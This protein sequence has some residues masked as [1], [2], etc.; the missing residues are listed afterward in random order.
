MKTKMLLLLMLIVSFYQP[1]VSN[2]QN[3]I[4]ITRQE[5]TT[6]TLSINDVTVNED[7][8]SVIALF[9]VTL[10]GDEGSDV[11][12]DYTTSSD[13]ALAGSDYVAT[14]GTLYFLSGSGILTQTITVTI[15]DDNIYEGNEYFNVNLINVYNAILADA[16]GSCLI[17]DFD[18]IPRLSV[19][20]NSAVEDAGVAQLTVTKVGLTKFPITVNFATADSTAIAG[21]DYVQTTG[22]I[23]FP[24]F[25]ADP[26][27]ISINLLDDNN[28]E[29]NEYFKVSLTFADN[30]FFNDQ[31]A[32]FTI[33]DD[34]EVVPEI[35]ISDAQANEG[36]TG[37]NN[38]MQFTLT[39][40][41]ASSQTVTVDAATSAGT[42]AAGVDFTSIA[43][44][45]VTFT[46]GQ[47]T[48]TMT[49]TL[50]G[51]NIDEND[52]TF[53]VNLSNA[54]N[55]EISDN[56]ATGTILDDDPQP[57][58]TINDVS[59]IEGASG[60]TTQAIFTLTLI[61]QTSKLVTVSASTSDNTA[62]TAGN[63][64]IAV[65]ATTITFN[66]GETSK[67]F[68]VTV[69]GDNMDE[70]DET[71]VVNLSGATNATISDNQATGTIL[72]DDPQPQITINDVSVNEG[73]SG[74][75]TQ[76]IFTLSLSSQTSKQ[77]TVSAITSDNTAT[78]AGNDY[79]AVNSTL[80]TFNPGD[81]SKTFTVTVNGDNADESD[82]SFLVNLSNAA[83][84][85]ISDNQALGTILDD[86]P[87]PSLSINDVSVTEGEE[88]STTTAVFVVTLT[89]LTNRQVTVTASTA[90]SSATIANEDYAAINVMELMFAPGETT[91]EFP[92]T[93]NGDSLIEASEYFKVNLST[94]VN[95]T[96]SDGSGIG[97][98]LND[99]FQVGDITG[100]GTIDNNDLLIIANMIISADELTPEL[101]A[102]IDFNHDG[103]ANILDIV[104]IIEQMLA[105]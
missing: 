16:N 7:G 63:D 22:S 103:V 20:D 96:I 14:N 56:Q 10:S 6:P 54:V 46:P 43:N 33:I 50:I 52:E 68:A 41:A 67:T 44:T 60:S 92:V 45:V 102:R 85:T 38:Q 66:P 80:I 49:V 53:V 3:H 13:D 99:D 51:D 76:A 98:I 18:P 9:T 101:L 87:L 95:A 71:F 36:N 35:T 62:T 79:T 94:P 1:I 12:V 2:A 72:D 104:Q 42:A 40:S 26:Q 91:K 11:W 55:A 84:A 15:L 30:A 23:L 37:T 81:T 8:A 100:D 105:K 61:G 17:T 77:V 83:N 93:V 82:E 32:I 97:T 34:D 90:D 88:D 24:A 27:T 21:E 86:D 89:G 4:E 48:K 28:M 65:S 5:P 73:A 78:T 74:S 64:Y 58:I 39:L 25:S 59:V 75:T 29:A 19:A 47:T 31:H 57:E 69:K 70:D